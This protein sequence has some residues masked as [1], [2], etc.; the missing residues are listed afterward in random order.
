M[1][2]DRPESGRRSDDLNVRQMLEQTRTFDARFGVGV[3]TRLVPLPTWKQEAD[4]F[5]RAGVVLP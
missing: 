2:G 4:F 5:V 1:Y 3:S